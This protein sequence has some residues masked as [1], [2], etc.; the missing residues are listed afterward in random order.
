MCSLEIVTQKKTRSQT[1]GGKVED[2]KIFIG[3]EQNGQ[4]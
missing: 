1:G 3:S 2:A 4:G